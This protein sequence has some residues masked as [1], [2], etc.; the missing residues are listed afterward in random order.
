MAGHPM[1]HQHSEPLCKLINDEQSWTN[2]KDIYGD[3]VQR[4]S[5]KTCLTH[6]V[7]VCFCGFEIGWHKNTD[8]RAMTYK[9]Q[10]AH[11]AGYRS[12]Y[13]RSYYQ[14]NRDKKIQAVKERR[15]RINAPMNDSI[16]N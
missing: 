10:Q 4:F 2:E 11:G 9:R 6:N 13:F 8:S 15:K 12:A 3:S 5:R 14:N 1:S 16:P 7:T